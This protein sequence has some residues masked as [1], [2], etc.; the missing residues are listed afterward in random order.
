MPAAGLEPSDE[1]YGLFNKPESRWS[2]MRTSYLEGLVQTDTPKSREQ[3]RVFFEELKANGSADV[4]QWSI[5]QRLCDTSA[6]QER[7][8]AEMVEAGV[9]PDIA[10]YTIMIKQLM[11]E[12]KS[13]EAHAMVK[14]EMPAAG[15]EPSHWT[16]E[17]LKKAQDRWSAMRTTHLQCLLQSGTPK[18]TEKAHV[19]FEELKANGSADVYQWNIMA[20]LF[21]TSAEQACNIG[22]MVDAGVK[23]NV[24]SYT[25]LVQQLMFEGKSEEA[26]AVVETEMPAAGVVPNER[27]RALFQKS[28]DSWGKMRTRRLQGLLK[29][30]TPKATEQAHVFFD[31]LKV[32]G[33]ASAYHWSIMQRLC[34]TS[35]K[36]QQMLG[37][38]VDAGV[39]PNAVS[40]TTLV[41]QLIFEG[42]YEDAKAVV[43]TEM[44]AAGVVT[45]DR[46]QA[47]INDF[48]T[49][50][51]DDWSRMRMQRLTNLF[52]T[53]TPEAIEQA[54]ALFGIMKANE[55]TDVY[56]WNIMGAQ[57]DT[58]AE[59]QNMMGEMAGVGVKP[60]AVSYA[61]LVQQL[62]IE[63]KSK[64]AK[65]VVGTEMPAARVKP[66]ERTRTMFQKGK[67]T[68]GRMRAQ[69]L[70]G[71][72]K[73]GTPKAREQ[74]NVFFEGLKASGAA[75]VHHW[76]IMQRLCG[77]S[78]E[79]Q[80]MMGEMVDAGMKPNAV[81]Y[82]ILVHQLMIEGKSIEAKA[83]VETEMP[84]AG[85][86][87]NDRTLAII[88]Q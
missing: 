22:E 47:I 42:N 74:A 56:L 69:R 26:E 19:F 8:V 86:V 4:Y 83:V 44:P 68:W 45:N 37:D 20:R 77:A 16:L 24:S 41:Q 53:K 33:A 17:L 28:D 79:Q 57:C 11:F 15:V 48:F 31:G 27:T 9:K 35:A 50:S 87:P 3:A 54:H 73:T 18:A 2:M 5:M 70:Q 80:K 62:M 38:M 23:P 21:D 82:A 63:G 49:K 52:K 59:Q 88:R 40:Y 39:K 60:N 32:N 51:Q 36:Q 61:I 58:S 6:E 66:N 64:E 85:V 13:K 55:A 1:V 25:M 72:L 76:S 12:G 71:L 29:T 43:E 75:D 78:A 84:A 67:D 34:G 30:G 7:V 65:A 10:S 46:A 14:T 81:S